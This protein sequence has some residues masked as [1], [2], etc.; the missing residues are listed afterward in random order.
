M[1]FGPREARDARPAEP[2]WW[3]AS[4]G[5][6]YPPETAPPQSIASQ[7]VPTTPWWAQAAQDVSAAES[8]CESSEPDI[9]AARD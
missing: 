6:W 3:L 5:K 7:P 4:D 8:D 2:G 9:E 1:A